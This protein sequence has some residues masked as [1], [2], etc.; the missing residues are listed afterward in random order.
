MCLKG[1]KILL[2]IVFLMVGF[3]SEAQTNDNFS[4]RVATDF[5][6]GMQYLPNGN[7]VLTRGIINLER[8]LMHSKLS[9]TKKWFGFTAAIHF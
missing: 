1:L 3:N 8:H 2:L 6:G 4:G 5:M 9:A 7:L